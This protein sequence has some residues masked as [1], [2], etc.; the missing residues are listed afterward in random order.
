MDKQTFHPGTAVSHLEPL[1]T[2]TRD[3]SYPG[4]RLDPLNLLIL[5]DRCCITL[6][7]PCQSAIVDGPKTQTCSMS[8]CL[9]Q[10]RLLL[11]PVSRRSRSI[12]SKP[13]GAARD[14]FHHVPIR[15]RK[16]TNLDPAALADDQKSPNRGPASRESLLCV[17]VCVCVSLAAPSPAL[18]NAMMPRGLGIFQPVVTSQNGIGRTG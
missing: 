17:C 13:P 14:V 5:C 16:Q 15:H 8:S 2:G 9:L 6:S 3:T 1:P 10:P 7:R 18:C 11:C 12:Y 4:K